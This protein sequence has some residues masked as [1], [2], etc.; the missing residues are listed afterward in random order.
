M[1]YV[2]QFPQPVLYIYIGYI[3]RKTYFKSC[4]RTASSIWREGHFCKGGERNCLR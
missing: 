3:Q 1:L 2:V 4:L